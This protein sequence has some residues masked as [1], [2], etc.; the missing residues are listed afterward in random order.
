MGKTGRRFTDREDA[1]LRAH[2]DSMSRR[3]M[4]KRLRRSV[5]A[6]ESRSRVLGLAK[7]RV[8]AFSPKE[9][10][11]IRASAGRTS[12][13]VAQQLVRNPSVVR[14]RAKRLGLGY[15]K[16]FS[17]IATEYRGYIIRRIEKR[18]GV[19]QRI[20]EHRAIMEE[21]IGRRLERG[22]RVHHINCDKRD[23]R[24]ENLHLF[25]SPVAHI[26][27]HAQL[28]SLIA[29]LLSRGCILFDRALGV[30]VLCATHKH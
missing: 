29:E 16:E 3:D 25:T 26:Q 17:P 14:M 28:E 2:C 22:E 24:I 1:F 11:I 20:P 6:V 30:Y 23:N 19:Y 18:K 10:R 15:W 4:A 8:R 21:H 7:F 5:R 13:D 9:D 27:T 12:V